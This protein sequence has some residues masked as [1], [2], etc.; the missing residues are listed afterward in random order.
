MH[1]HPTPFLPKRLP[2][3]STRIPVNHVP[4]IRLPAK[5]VDALGDLVAR[6]VPQPGEE[7]EEFAMYRCRGGIFKDDGVEG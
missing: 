3:E 6:R 5:L 4:E 1:Q 2:E 7:R